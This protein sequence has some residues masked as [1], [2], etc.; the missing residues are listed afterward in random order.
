M[1]SECVCVC[2]CVCV[3]LCVCLYVCV[4]V[5]VCLCVRPLHCFDTCLLLCVFNRSARFHLP[6]WTR[7]QQQRNH[8]M[9]GLQKPRWLCAHHQSGRCTGKSRK[10]HTNTQSAHGEFGLML[11]KRT[12][13]WWNG[14]TG[15]WHWWQQCMRFGNT[16]KHTMSISYFFFVSFS[17]GPRWTE[18]QTSAIYLDQHVHGCGRIRHDRH[19]RP[20]YL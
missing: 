8:K 20:T 14:M 15:I 1:I 16:A 9:G 7:G 18:R 3:C 4:C 2:V 5:C 10:I 19:R 6:Y 13:D 11:L 17:S 12:F